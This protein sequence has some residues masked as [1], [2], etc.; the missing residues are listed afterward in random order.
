MY[1]LG[2][3]R[4]NSCQAVG[5]SGPTPTPCTFTRNALETDC[6]HLCWTTRLGVTAQRSAAVFAASLPRAGTI[7]V[8][9]LAICSTAQQAACGTAQYF[10]LVVEKH[11]FPNL[12]TFK[13]IWKALWHKDPIAGQAL[14]RCSLSA[15][16]RSHAPHISCC[17]EHVLHC[18]EPCAVRASTPAVRSC[19]CSLD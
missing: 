11:G 10:V 4:A 9:C 15:R 18:D 8:P 7:A 16:A 6:H 17:F 2:P 1:T 13:N 5:P 14:L 19:G 12:N 3:H